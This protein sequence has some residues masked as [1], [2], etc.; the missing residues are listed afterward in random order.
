MTSGLGRAF[1]AGYPVAVVNSVTRIPQEP[2]ADVTATPA[3]ALDQVRE[4]ML[5]WSADVVPLETREETDER[6]GA[7][8]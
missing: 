7:D 1:P 4:V 6:E 3:A 8:E 5:I 2:F